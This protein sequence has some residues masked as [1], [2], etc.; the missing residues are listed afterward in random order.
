M[1]FDRAAYAKAYR[2]ANREKFRKAS[3]KYAKANR[4]SINE[5][6]RNDVRGVGRTKVIAKLLQDNP[7]RGF[8]LSEVFA[9]L[10]HLRTSKIKST[11]D[12]S[13]ALKYLLDTDV[14]TRSGWSGEF[15]YH[16]NPNPKA[17]VKA[18]KVEPSPMPDFNEVSWLGSILRGPLPLGPG[19]R[20]VDLEMTC[21]SY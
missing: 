18:V 21:D 8:K 7:H 11:R 17:K 13:R 5:R 16:W 20:I 4:A 9:L 15:L 2:A 19:R 1:T 12:I 3:S 10:P 6:A 14:V